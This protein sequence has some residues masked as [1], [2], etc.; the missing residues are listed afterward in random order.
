M[1]TSMSPPDPSSS[2]SSSSSSAP[3]PSPSPE[4][5]N[6]RENLHKTRF[7]SKVFEAPV[8]SRE[9]FTPEEV[10]NYWWSRREIFL[11]ELKKDD[12]EEWDIRNVLP[13]RV[14]QA[15]AVFLKTVLGAG[16]MLLVLA[17]LSVAIEIG[18]Q[19]VVG[20][21]LLPE[22]AGRFIVES[23]RPNIVTA[24][25]VLVGVYIAER[26]FPSAKA[27]TC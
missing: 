17:L 27:K 23:V 5:T 26:R 7:A 20:R 2:S 22:P 4:Q 12:E 1:L 21:G 8:L 24:L 6:P 13:A 3:P 16:G 14:I 11:F 18:G 15:V 19:A 25:L 10:G 9:D